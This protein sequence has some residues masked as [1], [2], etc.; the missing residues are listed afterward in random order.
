MEKG[1]VMASQWNPTACRASKPSTFFAQDLH[2]GMMHTSAVLI[3]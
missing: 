2:L 3:H 1:Y